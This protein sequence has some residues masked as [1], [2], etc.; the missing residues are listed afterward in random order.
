M[1]KFNKP[2]NLNGNELIDQLKAAGV[3]VTG[4]PELDEDGFLLLGIEAKDKSK[5]E[6]IVASHNG[7]DGVKPMTIAEKLAAVGITVEE[8]LALKA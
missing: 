8:I 6:P 7:S 4:K 3:T 1:I 5:A 2:T